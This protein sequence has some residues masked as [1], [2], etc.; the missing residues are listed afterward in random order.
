VRRR[1]KLLLAVR[2]VVGSV[3]GVLIDI[4]VNHGDQQ[5]F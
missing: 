4:K 3:C 2:T 1:W 5:R